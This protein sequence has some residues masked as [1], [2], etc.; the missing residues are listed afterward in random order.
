MKMN[1][2]DGGLPNS[3]LFCEVDTITRKG[4]NSHSTVGTEAD[5]EHRKSKL[6]HFE[7]AH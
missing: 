2:Y 7:P 4:A 3:K 6:M 5:K 1:V